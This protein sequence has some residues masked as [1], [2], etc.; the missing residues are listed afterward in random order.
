MIN[1]AH[2]G[3]SEYAPENTLSAFYL[4]LLQGADGIET[5]V[6]MTKDG[7]LVLF[8]DDTLEGVTDGK[9]RIADYT[10]EELKNIKVYGCCTTGFYDHI[11]TLRE[12]LERFSGYGISFAIELKADGTEQGVID[13]IHKF[14]I[15]AVTTVTSFG[16]ERI[17]RTKELDPS[18][19]V[20]LLTLGNGLDRIEELRA[21]GG[22]EMCPQAEKMT[23]ES[24]GE[25][26]R[27][28]LGVRAWGISG[29]HAYKYMKDMCRYGVDGMTVNFP[30]RL[31]QYLSSGMI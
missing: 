13:L 19:R 28:G 25:L 12:F 2:R 9:G 10:L 15:E 11:V 18:I 14:R 31:K 3:A 29:Y 23:V 24:V 7:V 16:F 22:E 6:Q 27:A 8:H 4:G 17:K 30:D 5:D 21:I 26:R 1:Y 20:G